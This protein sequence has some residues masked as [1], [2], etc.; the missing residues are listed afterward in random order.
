MKIIDINGLERDCL[1]VSADP[2][3]PGYAKITFAS[4]RRPG[5]IRTEW[6]PADDFFKLN[7]DL[8][9]LK[10]SFVTPPKDTLGVV[11]SSK[12]DSLKDTTQKW[13]PNCYAG[14]TVWISRG[15]GEGQTRSIVKNT[16]NTLYIDKPWDTPPD[17]TSQYVVSRN[18]HNP[19][20]LNNT[21]PQL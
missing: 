20:P 19:V 7:P 10:K 2:D 9:A 18:I 21:L 14:Y 5:E 6:Y 4:K 15:K 11:T 3:Y 12:A 1:E 17:K 8:K 13:Q 16:K